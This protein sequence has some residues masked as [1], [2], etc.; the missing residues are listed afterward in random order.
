MSGN[1]GEV[2]TAVGRGEHHRQLLAV[3]HVLAPLGTRRI[4]L[5]LLRRSTVSEVGDRHRREV[6]DSLGT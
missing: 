1:I 2:E 4:A 3:V 5:E 6:V